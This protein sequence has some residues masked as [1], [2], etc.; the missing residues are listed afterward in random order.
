MHGHEIRRQAE[1]SDVERWGGVKVG[2]LYGMLGR[3]EGEGLITPLRREQEGRRPVRT[4]Y[5]ITEAGRQELGLHRLR[6]LSEPDVR[7]TTVEVALKW[8]A[9]IDLDELRELVARRRVALGAELEQLRAGREL[10]LS[11]NELPAASVAGY[12][13]SELHLEAEI[14]WHDELESLL[15]AVVAERAQ[16]SASADAAAAE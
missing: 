2:A 5:A 6:A 8:A 16:Q 9:G 1:M 12:R 7:S 13:R 3:L 14:A 4:V 11:R 15:P 10:H